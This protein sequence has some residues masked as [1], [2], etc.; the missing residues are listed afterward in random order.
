MIM[1]KYILILLSVTILIISGCNQTEEAA[2]TTD[3]SLIETTET[4]TTKRMTEDDSVIETDVSTTE[5]SQNTTTKGDE[6]S[7]NTTT[8]GDETSQN[9]TTKDVEA[10]VSKS[11]KNTESSQNTTS[12]TEASQNAS[13]KD[14][15]ASQKASIKS[16]E[17]GQN[18]SDSEA[19]EEK[20][21]SEPE[22]TE[23]AKTSYNPNTVVSL[24]IS[25][26][27]AG[28]MITTQDNLANALAEGRITKEEYDEYYP[29]DGLE[30]SYYS[31]FVETDLNVAGTLSG[32][33]LRSEDAIA[34]YIADM[35]LLENGKVFNIVYAG[36]YTKNGTDFYEF[37][38]L[39]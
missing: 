18:T 32:R 31:V 13:A 25:K 33:S 34:T 7:Q 17:T 8:K 11:T 29:Y 28:G 15:E 38:C 9:T 5:T 20:Q 6:T 23:T 19:V 16:T 27:K 30:T 36:V 26:C 3:E 4:E 24:A 39:R 12:S 10:G 37:R 21:Q 35:L 2:V 1:K 22:T 14:T